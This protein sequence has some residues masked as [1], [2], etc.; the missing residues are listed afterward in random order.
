[1]HT[2]GEHRRKQNNS[3]RN[4]WM[5]ACFLLILVAVTAAFL[6]ASLVNYIHRSDYQI[7]LYQG[8]ITK[9][10]NAAATSTQASAV[11]SNVTQITGAQA[12]DL[13]FEVTDDENV[14]STN[15]TVELFQGSYTNDKG[16]V[17]VKSAD[18]SKIVAPGTG[19]SYTFSLKNASKLD[20]NYQVWMEADLNL[21]AVGIPIEFRMSGKD[22]WTDGT[23]AWLTADELNKAVARKNLYS[24]K[25]TEYTLYWRW[26]YERGTDQVDTAY[27]NAGIKTDTSGTDTPGTSTPGTGDL[28]INQS[29]SYKVTLHTLASEGLIKEDGSSDDNNDDNN[30][31]GD[32]NNDNNNNNGDNNDDNNNNNGDNNDDNNNNNGN[33]GDNNN[34]SDNNN[35]NGNNGNNNSN[36][37]NNG[38][39]NNNNGN[40]NTSN[41]GNSTNNETGTSGNGSYSTAGSSSASGTAS[42][43]SGTRRQSVR[44]G[45][46]TQ[47]WQWILLIAV[48]AAAI[49]V[50]AVIRRRKRH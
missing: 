22:G 38:S 49:T 16:Q 33:N 8:L 48:A 20:S 23:G 17:T 5:S 9:Q 12:K 15:T 10:Q 27:G 14:W 24:G 26:A 19:G 42:N 35:N 31:N 41:N 21:S 40:N 1:M 28:T 46:T 43:S 13:D 25:S 18:G 29:I 34:N 32:N 11:S 37:G 47:I 30:G 36:N 44:T 50:T 7:S 4:I 39:S 3:T 2:S 6:V 45:D